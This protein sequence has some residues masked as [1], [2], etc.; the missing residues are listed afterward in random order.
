MDND[1]S[2]VEGCLTSSAITSGHFPP[3]HEQEYVAPV[4]FQAMVM[5]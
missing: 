2:R 3:A 5:V 4:T 1:D